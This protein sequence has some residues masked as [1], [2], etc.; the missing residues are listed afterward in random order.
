MHE[1]GPDTNTELLPPEAMSPQA[2]LTEADLA[3]EQ[4]RGLRVE[5]SAAQKAGDTDLEKRI[6]DE[7]GALL[8]RAGSLR[9][10]AWTREPSLRPQGWKPKPN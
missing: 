3:N 9:Y 8:A 7:A 6:A 2:A 4:E 10:S 1:Q 5:S